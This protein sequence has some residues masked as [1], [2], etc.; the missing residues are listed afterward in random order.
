[1]KSLL[2][3]YCRI[4][5]ALRV[6]PLGIGRK[7][8]PFVE[9]WKILTTVI[10]LICSGFSDFFFSLPK[11]SS[12]CHLPRSTLV[13]L[14]SNGKLQCL[15]TILENRIEKFVSRSPY[16]LSPFSLFKNSCEEISS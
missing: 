2:Y 8:W 15:I 1:M 4:T 6:Y 5:C 3:T 13:V 12:V 16:V 9:E 11:V 10:L 7:F 14:L